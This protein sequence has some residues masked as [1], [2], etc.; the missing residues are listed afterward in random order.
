[1]NWCNGESNPQIL[2]HSTALFF[3]VLTANATATWRRLRRNVLNKT[4]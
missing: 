1:M 3:S 2:Q 4:N